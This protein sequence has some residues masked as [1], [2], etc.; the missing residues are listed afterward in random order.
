[1][2]MWDG[3]LGNREV[4]ALWEL[5]VTKGHQDP[6]LSSYLNLCTIFKAGWFGLGVFCKSHLKA[7][8]VKVCRLHSFKSKNCHLLRPETAL[9]GT[10]TGRQKE[11]GPPEHPQPPH[12]ASA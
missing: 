6:E 8:A 12:P 10:R 7:L 2:K 1:M 11:P 3:G 5:L 4:E 9:Q